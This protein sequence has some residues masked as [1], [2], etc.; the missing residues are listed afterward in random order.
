VPRARPLAV[1]LVHALVLWTLSVVSIALLAGVLPLQRALVVHAIAAPLATALVMAFFFGAFGGV[2]PL[3]AALLVTAVVAAGD[4]LTA[5]WL[6]R[7]TTPFQ[8]AL[9][10]WVPWSLI[11]AQSLASGIVARR[12]EKEGAPDGPPAGAAP[13]VEPA[14]PEDLEPVRGL[15]AA[16]GLPAE[17]V[18]EGGPVLWVVRGPEGLAGCVGLEVHGE[19]GLLRSLAVEPGRRGQ[20]LARAL[21]LRAAAEA[22]VLGVREL[23]LLTT[24][25]EPIFARWGFRR[26]DRSQ[27]PPAIRESREF[28]SLCPASAVFM[29]RRVG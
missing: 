15:L 13:P 18:V 24:T 14:R 1:L 20:G 6:R 17:D 7:A 29:A 4:L 23:F 21:C 22:R 27:A 5:P 8:G 19:A 2:A 11:F 25:A 10:T 3:P 26:V 16:C 9:E 12:K 28:A